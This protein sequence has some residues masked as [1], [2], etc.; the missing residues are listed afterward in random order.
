ML[1]KLESQLYQFVDQKCGRMSWCVF[2]TK[3]F[4]LPVV[5][6]FL[7]FEE[8][9]SG[10]IMCTC[11]NFI[12]FQIVDD[13]YSFKF[14][15]HKHHNFPSWRNGLCLL[16]REYTLLEAHFGPLFWPQACASICRFVFGDVTTTEVV[17]IPLKHLQT[18]LGT[19]HTNSFMVNW[20]GGTHSEDNFFRFKCWCKIN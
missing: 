7:D 8:V 20:H 4:C 9:Q 16:F 15:K 3:L 12:L 5:D 13:D 18:D 11:K 2:L 17:W 19:R 6:I 14:T 10:G 1:K